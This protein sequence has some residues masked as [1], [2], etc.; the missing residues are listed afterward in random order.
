[1]VLS[2]KV[3]LPSTSEMMELIKTFYD[4]CEASAKPVH[5]WHNMGDTEVS[6]TCYFLRNFLMIFISLI[7]KLAPSILR[8]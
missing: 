2:G 4:Q 8:I 1:M 7:V 3:K 5:Q 6:S